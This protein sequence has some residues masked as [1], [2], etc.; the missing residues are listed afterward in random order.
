VKAARSE[1]A[2]TEIDGR[3]NWIDRQR[4]ASPWPI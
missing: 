1:P 4:A 2:Y 3:E